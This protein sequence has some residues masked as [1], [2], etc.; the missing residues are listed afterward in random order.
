MGA[1]FTS[2]AALYQR[3]LDDMAS[4]HWDRVQSYSVGTGGTSRTVTYRTWADFQAQLEFVRTMAAQEGGRYHGRTYAG[5][6]GRG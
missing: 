6:G 1:V 2:W 3:M 4:G 5:S